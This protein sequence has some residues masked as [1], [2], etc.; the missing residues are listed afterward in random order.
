MHICPYSSF[1]QLLSAVENPTSTTALKRSPYSTVNQMSLKRHED[2]IYHRGD[3]R[4]PETKP[5]QE[6]T[7]R[8]RRDKTISFYHRKSPTSSYRYQE[9]AECTNNINVSD[10]LPLKIKFTNLL[11]AVASALLE[12]IR[13]TR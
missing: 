10:A 2:V 8:V 9:R 5:C 11:A 1:C 7:R 13:S 4:L 12:C 6:R 3:L